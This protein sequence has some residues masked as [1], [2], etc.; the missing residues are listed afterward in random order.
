MALRARL[1]T[2]EL[3][4]GLCE[5]GHSKSG[6][7]TGPYCG[8]MAI[9]RF[10]PFSLI[11]TNRVWRFFLAGSGKTVLWYDVSRLSPMIGS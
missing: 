8:S 11:I 3:Q 1:T 2:M 9:V 10:P 5:V 6:R 7:K 4:G